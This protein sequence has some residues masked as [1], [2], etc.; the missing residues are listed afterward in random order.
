MIFNVTNAW[1]AAYQGACVG[2]LAVSSVS[3][4]NVHLG[5][6]VQK[7][8]LEDQ[9]RA[10]FAGQ[11]RRA[12]A[13][14]A[15]IQAYEAYYK[16]FKKTYHVQLQ[17]ESIAFKGKAIPSVA[18]LVEAMF[19][20]EV[21]NLLLTAGHDLET[22]RLPATLDVATGRETYTLLRGDE[23]TLKEGDMF[24]A[25]SLGVISSIL[26]GPDQRT[27]ITDATQKALFTVYAPPGIGAGSVHQHLDDLLENIY[28]VSPQ[29]R[30]ELLQVYIAQAG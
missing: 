6:E 25:D 18:A 27:Q 8:A 5:L 24:I 1:R 30:V 3:N 7:K 16:R 19:M 26:Y 11:D 29:A 13:A 2:V 12:V 4:P 17:L 10:H 20:A 9:I 14:L 22:L 23:Q 15:P 21:K 28:T